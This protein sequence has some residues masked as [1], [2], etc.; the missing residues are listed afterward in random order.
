MSSGAT[1]TPGRSISALKEWRYTGGVPKHEEETGRSR[2]AR[3]PS[4]NPRRRPTPSRAARASCHRNVEI[5]TRDEDVYLGVL[6]G[7]LPPGAGCS[8]ATGDGVGWP[9]RDDLGEPCFLL[10]RR[11][12]GLRQA[13]RSSA[14][15]RSPRHRPP[16]TSARNTSSIPGG[17]RGPFVP[18]QPKKKKL[19]RR[20]QLAVALSACGRCSVRC[21]GCPDRIEGRLGVAECHLRC[22]RRQLVPTTGAP[23]DIASRYRKALRRSSAER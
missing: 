16:P 17:M 12:F 2:E 23:H 1:T 7:A 9:G 21:R 3:G 5:A 11:A 14:R 20:L 8:R 6:G 22:G 13:D 4:R 19:R 18:R 15:S 10:R